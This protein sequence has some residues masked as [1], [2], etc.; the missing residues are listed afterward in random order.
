MQDYDNYNRRLLFFSL[1]GAVNGLLWLY[2]PN[3]CVALQYK[4][5]SYLVAALRGTEAYYWLSPR[6]HNVITRM[7]GGGGVMWCPET[8]T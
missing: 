4:I 3:L 8:C 1:V 5:A 7:E 2:R 6:I